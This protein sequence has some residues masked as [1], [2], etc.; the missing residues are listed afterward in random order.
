VPEDV[1]KVYIAGCWDLL[2]IGHLNIL[3]RAKALGDVLIVGVL[4]DD[5]AAAYKNRPIIR[6]DDRLCLVSALKCVDMAILQSDTDPTKN[7]ELQLIDPDILV[8]GDDWHKIPG[9]EWMF[10]NRKEVMFLDYTP[11]VSTTE[12]RR[13]CERNQS[14]V[15]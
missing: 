13:L 2:H 1:I 4:T 12:I 8:H 14:V 15:G 7:G 10:R 11:G 6:E 5:G 3:Q 9:Q